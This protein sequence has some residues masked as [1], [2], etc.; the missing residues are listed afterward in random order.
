MRANIALLLTAPT[1]LR[2]AVAAWRHRAA[3]KF[4]RR[5]VRQY[6]VIYSYVWPAPH[7]PEG[8]IWIRAV[9]RSRTVDVTC[10]AQTP[11]RVPRVPIGTWGIPAPAARRESTHA[12]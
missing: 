7:G 8:T 1:A 6:T 2:S 9:R 10:R 4:P 11:W 3:L 12:R 5:I